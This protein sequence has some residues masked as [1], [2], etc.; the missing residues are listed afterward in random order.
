MNNPY[1]ADAL[2]SS[3]RQDPYNQIPEKMRRAIIKYVVNRVEPGGFLRALICN[4][5]AGAVLRADSEDL[6]LLR[7]YILWFYN[8]TSELTGEINHKKHTSQVLA[9]EGAIK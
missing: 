3:F 6:P 8:T 9:G 4:D 2:A 7:V 5:L 1:N